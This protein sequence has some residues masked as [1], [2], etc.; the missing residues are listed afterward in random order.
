MSRLYLKKENYQKAAES[1]LRI[2]DEN[3]NKNVFK[4][5][6]YHT[7]IKLLKLANDDNKMQELTKEMIEK[8][9]KLGSWKNPAEILFA[10]QRFDQFEQFLEETNELDF[11][12]E[13]YAEAGEYERCE[14]IMRRMPELDK[15]N[16]KFYKEK[17]IEMYTDVG[18][19][20]EAE[21]IIKSEEIKV[22]NKQ[23]KQG[24]VS[25]TK[26]SPS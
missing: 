22:E 4:H 18:L 5:K 6:D 7:A 14:K 15:N 19:L 26:L 3:K 17:M 10:E 16:I 2:I 12:L 11:A 25:M 24:I 21:R 1:Y 13:K 9:L 20:D 8:N 23:L